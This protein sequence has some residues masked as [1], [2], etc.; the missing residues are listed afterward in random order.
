MRNPIS[1]ILHSAEEI[2]QSLREIEKTGSDQSIFDDMAQAADTI[3]YCSNHQRRIVDDILTL[4]RLDSKL[5][6][7]SPAPAQPVLLIRSAL[8]MFDA[9]LKSAR[10][11]LSVR[12]DPSLR[13]LK[14]DWLLLDSG[15]V[16][17]IL[18]NL[19][20][21]AIKFTQSEPRRQINVT[22]SVS[23]RRPSEQETV[24]EYVPT[25][26]KRGVDTLGEHKPDAEAIYLCL[27]VKDTGRGLTG[28]E[29]KLLFNRFSQ[30]SP[31]THTQYGGSGLG[32]FISRQLSEMQGGEIG[33]VSEAGRGSTFVFYIKSKRTPEPRDDAELAMRS[34][35]ARRLTGDLIDTHQLSA[36]R[37]QLQAP[38]AQLPCS[39]SVPR[40]PPAAPKKDTLYILLAEDNIVNQKV[41]VKQL[42]KYGCV[43][44]VANHGEEALA[45]LR[46][47]VFWKG[48]DTLA[49]PLTVVLMDCEMPVMDGTTAVRRIRELEAEGQIQ[50]HVPVIA[51]TANARDDQ[52][53]A[54]LEAGM[55][56]AH[57]RKQPL[58]IQAKVVQDNVIT[59]PYRIAD[60]LLQIHELV[61]KYNG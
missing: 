27:A 7:I 55:V 58:G 26:G 60:L 1:A 15:R 48:A 54:A 20:T 38:H 52:I 19:M 21:N 29:K 5:L 25:Q 8:R 13:D 41:V 50:R 6:Q 2:L 56:S 33:L 40:G 59:K 32:L 43:V 39:T 23:Q 24:V 31:K 11:E 12:E 37:A 14:I 9:E 57:S 34:H 42:R 36:A 44:D 30:A 22:I 18:I 45:F 17:Q 4:S 35:M 49:K 46:N 16:L 53:K 61:Q 3:L 10:I 51:V 28:D 47:T